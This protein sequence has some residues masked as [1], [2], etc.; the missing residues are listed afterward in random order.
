[1]TMRQFVVDD[2]SKAEMDNLESYLQ[3]RL[4]AGAMDGMFW[5][6]LPD[7]LLAESQEGHEDCGPFC[8]GFELTRD[9]LIVELLVRSRSNMHC[10]CIAHATGDQRGFV[11]SFLDKMLLDEQIRA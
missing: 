3:D 4:D 6:N 8:F 10:S 9:K 11:L 1:M 2:L 7:D 5:L